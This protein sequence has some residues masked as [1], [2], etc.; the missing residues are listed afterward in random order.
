ML[1]VQAMLFEP[2][3]SAYCVVRAEC[4]MQ[5]EYYS[6]VSAL[7]PSGSNPSG[8][9]QALADVEAALA[10]D[11]DNVEAIKLKVTAMLGL[12]EYKEVLNTL[13]AH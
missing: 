2:L 9:S 4:Y 11:P 10:M 1:C 3:E 8:L 6:P 13:T 5:L 12:S 7:P